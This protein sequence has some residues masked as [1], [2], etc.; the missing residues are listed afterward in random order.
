MLVTNRS[1]FEAVV[2]ERGV[3]GLLAEL[4]AQVRNDP[5]PKPA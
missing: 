1:Q 3:A 5:P 2:A 4:R